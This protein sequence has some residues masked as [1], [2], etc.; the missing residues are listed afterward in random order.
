[1]SDPAVRTAT[2]LTAGQL[3][4]AGASLAVNLL[5]ARVLG[6]AGRGELGL[7]VLLAQVAALTA[8]FGVETGYPAVLDRRPALATAM[9][10]VIRLVRWPATAVLL[11]GGAAI[12]IRSV[13]LAVGFVGYGIVLVFV[14]V[15]TTASTAAGTSGVQLGFVVAWQVL[16]LG[17]AGGLV[18][19][20]VRTPSLWLAAMSA[21]AIGPAL[22]VLRRR[23][24]AEPSDPARTRA[25]RWMGVKLAPS[26]LTGLALLRI[27]R[28]LVPWLSTLHQL[29]VYLVVATMT[30]LVDLPLR[31]LLRSRL[32]GLGAQIRAGTFPLRRVLVAGLIYCLL[33]G[34]L[35]GVLARFGVVTLFG[36]EYRDGVQLAVPLGLAS[37]LYS[38]SRVG[39][40]ICTAADSA[41]SIVTM[42]L[43]GIVVT[44]GL[45]V[46]LV[47]AHGAGGATGAACVAYGFTALVSA[48][49]ACRATAGCRVPA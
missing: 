11:L 30:E 16:L 13:P 32:P 48:V 42:D 26:V 37:G 12:A 39:A 44:A 3:L 22:V 24:D 36:P 25:A 19:F 6:P 29:G 27:D 31:Y 20:D 34:L 2:G 18:L 46:L 5:S 43:V 35:L 7:Y 49:C 14:S 28:L 15:L 1:M 10:D 17:V 23:S 4:V 47:P 8:V 38:F 45:C 40:W 9:A 33:A 21:A 41:F